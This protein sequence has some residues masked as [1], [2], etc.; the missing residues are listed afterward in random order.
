[1]M[2]CQGLARVVE[3]SANM[4]EEE[5]KKRLKTAELQAKKDR[6]KIWT[7]YV[8]PATNSK[9]IRDVNFTGKVLAW[10]QTFENVF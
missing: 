4:L 5:A 7:N 6:L 8:P 9:A 2:T 10:F 3:W 1:M